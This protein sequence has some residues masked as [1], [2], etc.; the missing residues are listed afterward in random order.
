MLHPANVA[1]PAIAPFVLPPVQDRAA[2]AGGVI[3]NATVLVLVVTVFPN[4]SSTVTTGCVT[5]AA[6][7]IPPPGCVV[8]T[9][10]AAAPAVIVNELLTASV[11]DPVVEAVRVYDPALSME[12]LVKLA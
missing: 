6:L 4:V 3:V 1:T 10:L 5:H 8:K 11:M 2:P 12:Q 7:L 9:T